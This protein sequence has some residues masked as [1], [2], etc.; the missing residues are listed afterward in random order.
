MTF[1]VRSMGCFE[2]VGLDAVVHRRISQR[3]VP[4]EGSF[5]RCVTTNT[6]MGLAS[7]LPA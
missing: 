1:G 6:S 5:A 3:D 7:H 4:S 2:S